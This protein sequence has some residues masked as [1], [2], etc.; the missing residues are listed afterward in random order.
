MCTSGIFVAS[1][2]H[3]QSTGRAKELN[4][5]AFEALLVS[6]S[7]H[8]TELA[9]HQTGM[10]GRLSLA[11]ENLFSCLPKKHVL[12]KECRHNESNR[13]WWMTLGGSLFLR[14]V[15]QLKDPKAQSH[16]TCGGVSEER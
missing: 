15:F 14:L 5:P 7:L 12:V 9:V 13:R 8:K 16:L 3:G 6:F 2:P 11:K 1:P 10:E 4:S